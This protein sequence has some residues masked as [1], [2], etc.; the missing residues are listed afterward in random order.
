M[1]PKKK[2]QRYRLLST[3]RGMNQIIFDAMKDSGNESYKFLEDVNEVCS[4]I[5][6]NL[7]II[8]ERVKEKMESEASK[9]YVM[10]N[11]NNN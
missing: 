3:L 5:I 10:K 8:K 2:I 9:N 6:N 4:I 1:L 7:T 11:G